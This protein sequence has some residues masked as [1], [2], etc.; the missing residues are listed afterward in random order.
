[1]QHLAKP[2]LV[3]AALCVATLLPAHAEMDVARLKAAIAAS[4][5]MSRKVSASAA[6]APNPARRSR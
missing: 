6:L 3:S 5:D 2:F 1:M 4:V